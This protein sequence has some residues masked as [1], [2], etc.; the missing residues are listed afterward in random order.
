MVEY[1]EREKVLKAFTECIWDMAILADL[2]SIV[3]DMPAAD[4]RPVVRGK[5][6]YK[7]YPTKNGEIGV[8]FCSKCNHAQWTDL[9]SFCPLCGADMREG[10]E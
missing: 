10:E 6:V 1:I 7:G 3:R 9:F 4:V 2:D 5:W 8:L